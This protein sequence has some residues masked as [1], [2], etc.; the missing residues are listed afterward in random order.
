MVNVIIIMLHVPILYYPVS[1]SSFSLSLPLPLLS[2]P[3]PSL[4]SQFIS[5]CVVAYLSVCAYFTVFRI[6]IFNLYYLAPRHST[7]EYSL[8]FSAV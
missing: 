1:L 7:D 6:R 8:L 4:P 3:S 5:V 2:S